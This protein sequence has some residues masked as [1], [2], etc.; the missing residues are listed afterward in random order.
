MDKSLM[1]FFKNVGINHRTQLSYEIGL[2]WIEDLSKYLG[3]PIFHQKVSS[4][5]FQFIMDKVHQRLSAWKAKILSFA[6]DGANIKFW[7][8]NWVQGYTSLLSLVILEVSDY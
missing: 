4:G 5:T 3:V 2:Q 7:R 6:G 8:D 1:F